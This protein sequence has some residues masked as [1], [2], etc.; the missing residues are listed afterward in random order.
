MSTSGGHAP[1]EASAGSPLAWASGSWRQLVTDERAE[2]IVS[3][4]LYAAFA[5]A[6]WLVG[7]PEDQDVHDDLAVA[8][9]AGQLSVPLGSHW[10]LIP[11]GDGR[12]WSPFPPVPALVY[13]PFIALGLPTPFSTQ[14]GA[15]I[16]ALAAPTMLFAL[17]SMS[18]PLRTA[19][20]ISAGVAGATFGYLAGTSNI[21]FFPEVLGTVLS[22]GAVL[23]AIRGRAPLAAGVLMGLAAGSRLPIGFALLLVGF[24]YWPNRANVL[25]V[26]LGAATIAVPVAL[27]NILRFGSPFEFGYGL[28]ESFWHPGQ[29]VTVEPYFRE[30]VVDPSYIPRSIAAMLLQGYEIRLDFPWIA[31]PVSGVGVPLSAPILLLAMRAPRSRT[32]LVA[33]IAFVLVML[34]NWAH[35]SWGFWQF[36]YRFIVDATI[37]LVILLGL[38]YRDRQPDWLV[39]SLALASILFTLY[40][41]AADF[42]W[43]AKVVPPAVLP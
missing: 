32:M 28:I 11:I 38:A 37:A 9:L 8:L 27:Y 39:R 19:T 7:L 35:G 10:E 30:G 36:G 29:L 2:I 15:V 41:F 23:L 43:N 14:L 25:Q 13:M 22:L 18:V 1:A 16:G 33:W 40:A 26:V 20:W 42:W 24:L 3:V 34:P 6:Y 4:A 31:Y 17:R 12:A 21:W 5:L